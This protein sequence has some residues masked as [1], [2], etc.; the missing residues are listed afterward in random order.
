MAS[1]VFK[2]LTTVEFSSLVFYLD[3]LSGKIGGAR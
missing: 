3:F 1:N 2:M